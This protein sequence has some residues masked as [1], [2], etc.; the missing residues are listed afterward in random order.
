M[1]PKGRIK[2]RRQVDPT[3]ALGLGT[4]RHPATAFTV[5]GATEGD[6]LLTSGRTPQAVNG[7]L[8][9]AEQIRELREAMSAQAAAMEELKEVVSSQSAEFSNLGYSV[10]ETSTKLREQDDVRW[11]KEEVELDREQRASSAQRPRQAYAVKP[12]EN[13]YSF[14]MEML[15]FPKNNVRAAARVIFVVM[16]IITEWALA[17]G[18]WDS[19]WLDNHLAGTNLLGGFIAPASFYP[20]SSVYASDLMGGGFIDDEDDDV[21]VPSINILAATVGIW[22]LGLAIY[23]DNC[24]TM[25]TQPPLLLLP[26]LM[27]GKG[28]DHME[29]TLRTRLWRIFACCLM[30]LAWTIRALFLPAAAGLGTAYALGNADNLLDLVLNSIAVAFIFEVDE[31]MYHALILP[32]I[33]KEYKEELTRMPPRH[34]I[35][36]KTVEKSY[37]RSWVFV[38]Y[39]LVFMVGNYVVAAWRLRPGW[40]WEYR[41]FPFFAF[42]M[43][44]LGRS[45]LFA[46]WTMKDEVEYCL[47]R[48]K[49]RSQ[50]GKDQKL[51]SDLCAVAFGVAVCIASGFVAFH[52]YTDATSRLLGARGPRST[53]KLAICLD[54]WAPTEACAG[55]IAV[56]NTALGNSTSAGKSKDKV[57]FT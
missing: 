45:M 49:R 26:S 39:D 55:A 30:H 48:R 36:K 11:G 57:W 6:V 10:R 24:V 27:S 40:D 33:Q 16:L 29:L 15:L 41:P 23:K 46:A 28:L 3:V 32:H 9:Q 14:M 52:L 35:T 8:R 4:R 56:A 19:S 18:F 47:K 13:L 21:A 17:F 5:L 53:S 44:V 38:W 50:Y 42:E 31:M 12:P 43:F 37:S 22:L 51:L 7:S 1:R 2:V 25:L 20:D 54:M 34:R